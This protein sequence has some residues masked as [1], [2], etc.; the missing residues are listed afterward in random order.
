MLIEVKARMLG[1]AAGPRS[2]E[3][4]SDETSSRDVIGELEGEKIGI[5]C[6]GLLKIL[7]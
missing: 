2:R 4:Q 7:C 1:G 3:A 5:Y 6:A